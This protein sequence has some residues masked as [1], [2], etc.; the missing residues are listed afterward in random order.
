MKKYLLLLIIVFVGCEKKQSKKNIY[1][2]NNETQQ[3]EIIIRPNIESKLI[4][5]LPQKI[6]STNFIV[7][8]VNRIQIDDNKSRISKSN[9][10]SRLYSI[11][12]ENLIFKNTNDN[13]SLRLTNNYIKIISFNQLFDS[14]KNSEN[15]LVY[16]II[17]YDSNFDGVLNNEDVSSLF[18]SNTNGTNFMQI[19]TKN[20]HLINWNYIPESEK[21]FFTTIIDLDKNG[22][23]DN[24]DK[25][26][27]H[28]LTISN[29]KNKTTLFNNLK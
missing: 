3:E 16:K 7:F 1:Q 29:L 5:D 15:L 25:H 27:I 4:V 14:N 12:L 8:P 23:F 18:I 11:P 19:T 26:Q 28:S 21:L 6:D 22:L 10:S 13:K 20:E 17:K 2:G 24:N 9:Y